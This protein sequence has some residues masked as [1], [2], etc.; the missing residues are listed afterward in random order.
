MWTKNVKCS[1][2]EAVAHL[3]VLRGDNSATTSEKGTLKWTVYSK[4][5]SK[6][7]SSKVLG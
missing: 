5:L 7:I 6:T 3:S 4:M 1:I 2:L